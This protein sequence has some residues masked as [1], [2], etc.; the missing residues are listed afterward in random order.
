M[1]L[2]IINENPTKP[3]MTECYEKKP[4]YENSGFFRLHDLL[5]GF[6]LNPFHGIS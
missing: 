2:N 5:L 3:S 1:K 4:C 6:K